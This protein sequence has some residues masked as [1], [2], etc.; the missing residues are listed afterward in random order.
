MTNS[1]KA[2]MNFL[3]SLIYQIT[4]IALGLLV[5]KLTMTEYGSDVNGLVNSVNQFVAY[6]IVFEAGIQVVAVQALYKN[7]ANGDHVAMNSILAAVN[8]KYKAI[9]IC[10]FCTLSMLSAIMPLIVHNEGISYATVFFVTFFSGLSN[11]VLFF[12]HG[13]YRIMLTVE[14]KSYFIYILNI[15]TT[16]LNH[17]I[18]IVLIIMRVSIVWVV[19]GSFVISL[20]PS[21]LIILYISKKY[22]WIDLKVKPNKEALSQNKEALFHQI[23]GLVFSN[24]DILLLTVFCDLKIVSVYTVYKL[25][26]DYIFSFSKMPFD[27]VSFRLGQLY[28]SNKEKFKQIIFDVELGSSMIAFSLFSV[29]ICLIIPFI[30]IY[31]S[32][33][34]D[35]N[36]IDYR[37]A[38]LFVIS[39]ILNI[40][41]IPMLST[42]NY[43]GHFRQTLPQSLLETIINLSV[44]VLG[45]IHLGIYGVLIGTIV[46]LLYRTVEIIIYAN[47]KLIQ[48]KWCETFT[49]YISESLIMVCIY[50]A[51]RMIAPPVTSLIGFAVHGIVLSVVSFVMYFLFALL[52]FKPQIT[53][54]LQII[55]KRKV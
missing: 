49:L 12:F 30:G 55:M 2:K 31:T 16:V 36:Y 11:V 39:E 50:A 44:S 18:K 1:K 24:T 7:V 54:F 29:C 41:R 10:Y 27:S 20:I 15:I 33:I 37:V 47:K 19:F 48:R 51:Y 40:I 14:G 23:A 28:N 8:E 25:V 13:K 32:G 46:A 5:P 34:K 9:G 6:L 35:I 21:C 4:A 38:V 17:G 42:I 43:A 26:C 22:K 52:F 45:V 3:L 53:H